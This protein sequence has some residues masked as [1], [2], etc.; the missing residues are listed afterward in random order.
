MNAGIVILQDGTPC[1]AYDEVLPFPIH[2]VEFS[3]EDYQVSFIYETPDKSIQSRK[4]EFPLD[5][6]FVT[7][8]EKRKD[9]AV[10]YIK[11]GDLFEIKMYSVVF[12]PD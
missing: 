10:A 8:L 6:P 1:I 11:N 5:R 12:V 2:H 3:R 4:F 7:L 9:V